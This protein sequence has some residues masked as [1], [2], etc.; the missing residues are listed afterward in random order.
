M[1]SWMLD[2]P[3]EAI[4]YQPSIPGVVFRGRSRRGVNPTP[5]INEA[6]RPVTR[7]GEFSVL[8]SCAPR[9]ASYR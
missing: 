5:P 2:V 3:G 8:E 1:L 9:G 7:A 6:W 4:K